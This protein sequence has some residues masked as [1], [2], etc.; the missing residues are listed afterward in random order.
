MT[1]KPHRNRNGHWCRC[2]PGRNA[3]G[4]PHNPHEQEKLGGFWIEAS[5]LD[6]LRGR[7][8]DPEEHK[9]LDTLES[10]YPNHDMLYPWLMRE[11]KKGRLKHT[12]VRLGQ[13][14]ND[15]QKDPHNM[16]Y[17]ARSGHSEPLEPETLDTLQ[18]HMKYMKQNKKGIDIMQHE[19]HDALG[20]ADKWDGSGEVVHKFGGGDW[21]IEENPAGGYHLRNED[22]NIIHAGNTPEDAKQTLE[23]VTNGDR[24]YY[25]QHKGWTIQRLRH[26]RDLVKEGERMNHCVGSNGMG[27]IE[28]LRDGKADYYSLRDPHDEPHATIEMGRF[29]N[30]EEEHPG[31]VNQHGITR[32]NKPADAEPHP[33]GFTTVNDVGGKDHWKVK[34]PVVYPKADPKHPTNETHE[35]EQM[36]GHSDQKLDESH[37]ELVNKW[38]GKHGHDYKESDGDPHF[39]PWWDSYYTVPGATTAS[40]YIDHANGDY[41]EYADEDYGSACFDAQEH[42]HDEPELEL[43]DPDHESVLQDMH[44]NLDPH[45]IHRVFKAARDANWHGELHDAA[46]EWLN[47]EYHPRLDPY[48]V[49]SMHP[50]EEYPSPHDE[51]DLADHC[52]AQN[53]QYHMSQDIDPATGRIRGWGGKLHP[54]V[55]PPGT[56]PPIVHPIHSPD[57]TIMDDAIN[58]HPSAPI[59]GPGTYFDH[60]KHREV[61]NN[62]LPHYLF[63]QERYQP[64]EQIPGQRNMW[65]Q[66]EMWGDKSIVNTHDDP[67]PLNSFAPQSDMRP[68]VDWTAKTAGPHPV[69]PE[70]Q[71]LQTNAPPGYP[72]HEGFDWRLPVVYDAHKNTHIIG[73]PGMEHHR[74]MQQFPQ[75]GQD[76]WSDDTERFT[77]GFV[78]TTGHLGNPGL[79][80]FNRSDNVPDENLHDY[81]EEHHGVRSRDENPYPAEPEEAWS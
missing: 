11:H 2:V 77:P 64:L 68:R 70:P 78:D 74:M 42:G 25:D 66:S 22:G 38:L 24:N 62:G 40:E 20:A 12:P 63:P 13:P 23:Q 51:N 3:P 10:N 49:G 61:L 53:L 39:E 72:K 50:G 80:W 71:I 45:E 15:W 32:W 67:Q 16:D 76:P 7:T 17:T 43:G 79:H 54:P 59:S 34:P 47:S 30:N 29:D 52:F 57:P 9:V 26:K 55:Q 8:E 1:N 5:K 75:Y 35:V 56:A 33:D 4:I 41:H 19:I 31:F 81:I 14:A 48:G 37:E 44:K 58:Q 6:W 65:Q 28:K 27:Y 73:Q 36:F 21:K 18:D 46:N 60:S 69:Q